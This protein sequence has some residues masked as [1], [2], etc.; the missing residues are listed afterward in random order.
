MK[1]NGLADH[2]LTT[3][4]TISYSTGHIPCN[5]NIRPHFFLRVFL[6]REHRH[7][8]QAALYLEGF[9]PGSLDSIF[10]KGTE[11]ALAKFQKARDIST[12]TNDLLLAVEAK[13]IKPGPVFSILG[14]GIS[15]FL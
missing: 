4:Q 10:G 15:S 7:L 1:G 11:T 13:G 12:E 5:L 14:S 8:Q 9:N 3:F 6:I 2:I